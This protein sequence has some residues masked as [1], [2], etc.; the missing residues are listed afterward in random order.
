MN[1]ADLKDLIDNEL[2]RVKIKNH[3][4]YTGWY[5]TLKPYSRQIVD[6]ILDED[7][8]PDYIAFAQDAPID[9]KH[10]YQFLSIISAGNPS[11][12]TMPGLTNFTLGDILLEVQNFG[13]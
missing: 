10:E 11:L 2:K 4:H 3:P 5:E 9:E 1:K 13:T 8:T 6:F 12:S 7:L